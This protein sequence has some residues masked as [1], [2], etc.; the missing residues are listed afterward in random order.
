MVTTPGNLI[1]RATQRWCVRRDERSTLLRQRGSMVRSVERSGSTRPGSTTRLADLAECCRPPPTRG[2][3][4]TV[5]D[6]PDFAAADLDHR[7][8]DFY[9]H[10]RSWQMYV[11]SQWS[12]A[13][14]PGAWLLMSVFARPTPHPGASRV[15]HLTRNKRGSDSHQSVCRRVA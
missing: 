15:S 4:L 6:R 9:E 10:T 2:C 1:D 14:A 5:L 8:V 13:F 11:W 3:C 12:P 7:V